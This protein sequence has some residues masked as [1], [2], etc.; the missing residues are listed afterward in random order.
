MLYCDDH[1]AGHNLGIGEHLGVIVDRPARNVVRLEN[2]QPMAARFLGRDGLNSLREH[3]SVSYPARVVGQFG[4][5]PPLRVAQHIAEPTKQALVGRAESDVAVGTSNGLV[6]SV[7]PVGRPHRRRHAH[8]RE[9][10]GGLPKGKRHS[11]IDE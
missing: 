1:V 4:Y 8:S 3:R 2:R 5:L 9:I 10:L 7:H 11:G 6:R